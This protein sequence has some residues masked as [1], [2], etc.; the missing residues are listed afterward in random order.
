MKKS[1]KILAATIVAATGAIIVYSSTCDV[2]LSDL[3][4]E[5]LEALAIDTKDGLDLHPS[6]PKMPKSGSGPC[7]SNGG[8]C[9]G[10]VVII[11]DLPK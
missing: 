3:Q 10:E 5:N 8:S 11:G 7:F 6:L 4:N 9:L 2:E 1:I